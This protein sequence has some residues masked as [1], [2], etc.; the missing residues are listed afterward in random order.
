MSKPPRPPFFISWF[1]R[2]RSD[3]RPTARFKLCMNNTN[4]SYHSS[5]MQSLIW[6]LPWSCV[7]CCFT[8]I[9]WI[10]NNINCALNKKMEMYYFFSQKDDGMQST[11]GK[12]K[13]KSLALYHAF[14]AMWDIRR[15]IRL[16]LTKLYNILLACPIMHIWKEHNPYPECTGDPFFLS[17]YF[18]SLCWTL[19]KRSFINISIYAGKTFNTCTCP[20]YSQNVMYLYV[21]IIFKAIPSR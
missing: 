13:N 15:Y 3:Q 5:N 17:V 18:F 21:V 2:I 7:I 6:V 11:T 8:Q 9:N 16:E 4:T 14:R 20:M 10:L 12:L 1:P 19:W